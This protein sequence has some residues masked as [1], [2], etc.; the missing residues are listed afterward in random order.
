[1][2]NFFVKG[3]GYFGSE[4]DEYTVGTQT[5][6]N[7]HSVM[8]FNGGIG[9]NAFF[10]SQT[11]L[12][13]CIYYRS[14]TTKEKDTDNKFKNNGIAASVGLVHSLEIIEGDIRCWMLDARDTGY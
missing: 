5:T 7:K 1:M 13:A 11:A 8:G 12:R 2:R 6:T 3:G 10:A 9:Y 14:I 4:Q